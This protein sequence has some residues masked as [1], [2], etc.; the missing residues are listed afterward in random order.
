MAGL[1]EEYCKMIIACAASS[2]RTDIFIALLLG[3]F[4]SSASM[5]FQLNFQYG[6][7]RSDR[8]DSPPRE[9]FEGCYGLQISFFAFALAYYE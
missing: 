4:D 3:R 1:F 8:K 7:L 5:W 9:Y 2:L 6:E